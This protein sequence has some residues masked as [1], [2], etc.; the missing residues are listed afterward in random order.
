MDSAWKNARKASLLTQAQM[1]KL[2]GASV[3]SVSKYEKDPMSMSGYMMRKWY[4][5]VRPVGQEMIRR[6][7]SGFLSAKI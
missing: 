2:I 5:A 1:G 4:G 3:P 7:M 6:D